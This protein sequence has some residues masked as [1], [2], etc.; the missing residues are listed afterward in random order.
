MISSVAP[1]RS[2]TSY[3]YLIIKIGNLKLKR[4]RAEFNPIRPG[5]GRGSEARMAK[6][7]SCQ[8]ET[9][10]SVMPKLCDF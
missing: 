3:S 5:G 2:S 7:N 4:M 1:T 6:L 9:S 10:Y 8:S